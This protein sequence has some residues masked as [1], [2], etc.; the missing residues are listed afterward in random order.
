MRA[1]AAKI[2]THPF[3]SDTSAMAVRSMASKVLSRAFF[4]ASRAV[5]GVLS[6]WCADLVDRLNR[7]LQQTVLPTAEVRFGP[8]AIDAADTGHP[9]FCD[10]GQKPCNDLGRS[11]IA[12]DQESEKSRPCRGVGRL[13]SAPTSRCSPSQSAIA[14]RI[15]GRV[16]A[17]EV[18]GALLS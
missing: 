16:F 7:V 4:V 10:F 9:I 13:S 2:S 8:V 12:V 5:C 18:D 15:V 6:H 11:V 14:K 1:D 17:S 3:S